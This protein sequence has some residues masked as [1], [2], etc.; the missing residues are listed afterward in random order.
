MRI[1]YTYSDETIKIL[2]QAKKALKAFDDFVLDEL[3]LNK[4]T[5]VVFCD[6]EDMRKVNNYLEHPERMK[7]TKLINQIHEL[8]VPIKIEVLEDE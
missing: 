1:K 8:S 4:D 6:I 2:D 7:L 5:P 3:N